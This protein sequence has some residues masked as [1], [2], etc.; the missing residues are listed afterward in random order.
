MRFVR[1]HNS[2][3]LWAA[4]TA[5]VSSPAVAADL[6]V[7]ASHPTLPLSASISFHATGNDLVITLTNSAQ[8]DVMLPLEILTAVYYDVS[9]PALGLGR[10]SAVIGPESSLLFPPATPFDPAPKGVGGEWEYNEGVTNAPFGQ[11]YAIRSAGLGILFTGVGGRFPGANLQ[12]PSNVNG[13]QY[14]ITSALDNSATGNSPVTGGA[15]ALIKNQVIFTLSGL[16]AGFDP[17]AMISSV[18]FQ[19]GTTRCDVEGT[20]DRCVPDVPEPSTLILIALGVLA[21]FGCNWGRRVGR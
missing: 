4:L 6:L 18:Q 11:A 7:S 21:H 2:F 3:C 8:T 17:L 1:P 12:G 20:V 10:T 16:P 19:Y 13:V 5:A 14:G 9:G 15:G